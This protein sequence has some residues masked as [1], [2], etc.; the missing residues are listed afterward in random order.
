M[1]G[2]IRACVSHR[3]GSAVNWVVL[4]IHSFIFSEF[5]H[6][7]VDQ[8]VAHLLLLNA[9]DGVSHGE[10]LYHICC[11]PVNHNLCHIYD[12]SNRIN[13]SIYESQTD[14]PH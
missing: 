5:V 13:L 14:F 2:C 12:L 4:Y 8:R 11:D 10:H 1:C 6:H 3:H 7:Q 9:H